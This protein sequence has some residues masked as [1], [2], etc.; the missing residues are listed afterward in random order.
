MGVQVLELSPDP[1][2][3]KKIFRAPTGQL[4]PSQIIGVMVKSL[5][6]LIKIYRNSGT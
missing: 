3:S 5:G 6:C 1:Q 4:K 2:Q